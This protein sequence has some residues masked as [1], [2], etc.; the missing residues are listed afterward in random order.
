MD[1]KVRIF[2]DNGY[3]LKWEEFSNYTKYHRQDGGNLILIREGVET[4][5]FPHGQWF[6]VQAVGSIPGSIPFKAE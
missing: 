3:S 4:V 5:E 1:I 2:D 6:A